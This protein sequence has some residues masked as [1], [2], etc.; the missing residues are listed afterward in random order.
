MGNIKK[1][2]IFFF[3]SVILW[4]V[5][6]A[7]GIAQEGKPPAPAKPALQK[8]AVIKPPIGKPRTEK[9]F[10]KDIGDL[11]Y[12]RRVSVSDLPGGIAFKPKDCMR[13]HENDPDVEGQIFYG[14]P[15]FKKDLNWPKY[16]GNAEKKIAPSLKYNFLETHKKKVKLTPQGD[17]EQ[18]L[19]QNQ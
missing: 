12:G 11:L 13:C 8:G 15:D 16:I 7:V 9:D 18:R 6:A 10:T 5:I 19:K 17:L 4:F 3:I 2:R 14:Y 1:F